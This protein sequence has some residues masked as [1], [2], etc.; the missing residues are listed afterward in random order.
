MFIEN[1][2]MSVL[3]SSQALYHFGS[4]RNMFQYFLEPHCYCPEHWSLIRKEKTLGFVPEFQ[5]F[6]APTIYF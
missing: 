4:E 1:K 6:L 5:E 2:T 3:Q